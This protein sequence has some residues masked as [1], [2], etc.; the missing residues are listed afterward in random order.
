MKHET[1]IGCNIKMTVV[2]NLFVHC[3]DG[4]DVDVK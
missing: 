4:V 3:D 1:R 2:C